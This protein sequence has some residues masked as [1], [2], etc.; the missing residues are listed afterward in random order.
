[1]TTLLLR[2]FQ[3]ISLLVLAGAEYSPFRATHL[4]QPCPELVDS[5]QRHLVVTPPHTTRTRRHRTTRTRRLA[6]TRRAATTAAHDLRDQSD[7]GGSSQRSAH[8]HHVATRTLVLPG[9]FGLSANLSR[10]AL[11]VASLVASL[12]YDRVSPVYATARGREL[13]VHAHLGD[14]RRNPIPTLAVD[15]LCVDRTASYNPSPALA[16]ATAVLAHAIT[17]IP[18][19]TGS[20]AHVVYI[21]TISDN[22]YDIRELRHTFTIPLVPPRPIPP[23]T[24]TIDQDLLLTQLA[25]YQRAY[26]AYRNALN[27]AHQAAQ[28]GAQDVRTIPLPWEN[29]S[30]DEWGCIQRASEAGVTTLVIASDMAQNGQQQVALHHSLRGVTIH[31]IDFRCGQADGH[32]NEARVCE[33]RKA[34]WNRAFARSGTTSVIWTFPGQP[35]DDLFGH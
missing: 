22:S 19:D 16:E 28:A 12:A 26:K 25:A 35:T 17:G 8:P 5:Q 23:N 1:M 14:G 31:I 4:V 18:R 20:G 9:W 11:L 10:I 15:Y 21:A 27:N 30:T 34:Y 33:A 13:E 6:R 32:G 24:N 3:R 7:T 2:C 29:R